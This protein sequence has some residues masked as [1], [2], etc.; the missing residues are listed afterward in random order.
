VRRPLIALG[1]VAITVLAVAAAYVLRIGPLVPPAPRRSVVFVA[2]SRSTDEADAHEIEAIDLDAGTR[3][4]FDA[5]GRI[6]AMALS[7]D[8]RSL[9][10]AL[11][12]GKIVCL[13]ATTGSVFGGVDLHGPT[14]AS[15]VPTADGRTLFA[16]TVTNIQSAV[17]PIDL[18]TRKSAD[19]ITFT[20]TAG[21]AVIRGDALFVP[22]GD[23][24]RLQVAFIDLAT[25]AVTSRLTLPRGSLVPA[26]A[27]GS[28]TAGPGSSRGIPASPAAA[29]ACA[30]TRSPTRCTGPMCSSKRRCRRASAARP[31]SAS[32]RPRPRTGPSTSAARRG[33]RPG[34]TS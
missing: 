29:P 22:L 8:R 32:R 14:I 13:D 23:P 20:M 15:L 5:G 18:A 4:L 1:V 9:Y 31:R 27:V 7:A 3:D 2:I 6:T 34:G 19:P 10:V 16:V 33:R 24:Q 25:R 28:A 21:P 11:D 26:A 30:S 12:G 17:V